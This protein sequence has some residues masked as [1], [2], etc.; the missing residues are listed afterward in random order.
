MATQLIVT[1]HWSFEISSQLCRKH[2]ILFLLKKRLFLGGPVWHCADIL[3]CMIWIHFCSSNEPRDV[4]FSNK[5]LNPRW[6]IACED[7]QHVVHIKKLKMLH[8]NSI[9][10]SNCTAR[11][12]VTGFA[13]RL[14]EYL[15]TVNLRLFSFK[16]FISTPSKPGLL[17]FCKDLRKLFDYLDFFVFHLDLSLSS[18]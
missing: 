16:P 13:W 8:L 9:L 4:N 5:W 6:W 2:K 10:G 15:E 1:S 3:N 17:E 11:H 14:S 18:V 7:C 12:G